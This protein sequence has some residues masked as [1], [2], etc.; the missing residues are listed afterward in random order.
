MKTAG[1]NVDITC[2]A[3]EM[4]PVRKVSDEI[5]MALLGR[6]AVLTATNNGDHSAGSWHYTNPCYATDWRTW[7][8]DH[9]TQCGDEVRQQIATAFR[10]KL[11]AYSAYYDVI[12]HDTHIHIEYDY[13][14][15]GLIK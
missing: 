7:V 6:E 12:V 2:L 3:P 1:K 8:D 10:I 4:Q 13:F 14:K 11:A 9:G 5:F 15:A